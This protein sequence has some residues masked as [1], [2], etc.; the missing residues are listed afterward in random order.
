[1][2]V[3]THCVW[4]GHI[5]ESLRSYRSG[6]P[7]ALFSYSYAY[8][9]GWS[10]YSEE[11][12]LHEALDDDPELAIGQLQNAL[13]NNVRALSSI[14]VHTGGMSIAESERLFRD[15][16]FS[17]PQTARLEAARAGFDPGAVMYSLGK[18]MLVK[19]RDDWLAATPAGTLREF[20]DTF[21]GWGNSPMRLVRAA[22][23]GE[24]DDGR[25]F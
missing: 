25:L 13:M 22:M 5:L 4:S 21:L 20:H 9:E 3:T 1:M 16:A 24:A 10:H 7:L 11:M 2:S 14:G 15:K 18:L 8:T 6:N 17:D 19:L 12:M 23:L